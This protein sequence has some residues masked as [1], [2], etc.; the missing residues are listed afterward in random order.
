MQGVQIADIPKDTGVKVAEPITK[1]ALVSPYNGGNLGDA[2]IQEAMIANLRQR[3]PGAQFLGITLDCDNFVRQHGGDAFPL[4]PSGARLPRAQ[5]QPTLAVELGSQNL[6]LEKPPQ[7]SI[8]RA[9]RGIPGLR[10]L[11][12]SV[13]T[14]LI[15]VRR[16]ASH[17]RDGYR[18]VRGQDLLV[19]SGGGQLD[20][21]YGGGWR[22]PFAIWKWVFLAHLAK[23][24]CALASVGAGK[25]HQHASRFFVSQALRMCTY[26]SFRE[27]KSRAIVAGI[28]PRAV[29]DA[30]V[31]DL[32]F[33]LPD[34]L[35][36]SPSGEIRKMAQGRPVIALSPMAYLKPGIW[37]NGNATLYE[38]YV[39]QLAEV[40][41][42]LSRRGYFFVVACSSRY[43]DESVIPELLERLDVELKSNLEGRLH[44]PLIKSW[45][46]LVGVLRQS[47][48]LIASRLHGTI[49][50]FVAGTP[51]IA[52]SSDPKVDW[53]MEDLQQTDYLLQFRDFTAEDV[54]QAVDRLQKNRDTCVEHIRSYRRQLFS[55]SVSAKQ[56]D[57]L[58]GL[59]FQHRRGDALRESS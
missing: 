46:E 17:W 29:N 24:P 55:T 50:G 25:L 41:A 3:L 2:A 4:L 10:S 48:I 21:E 22:L 12:R 45:P 1:I 35:L 23:V 31:P 8:R 27:P 47:D 9:L 56:Y 26:R 16:H 36:P 39:Q 54:L 58:A 33:S 18:A 14:C 5:N 53:V 40:L 43:D 52:I 11:V 38:R 37:P 30:V 42:C 20:E 32:A 51:V 34:S 49:L 19:I 6:P 13:R 57:L 7:N 28:L 15:L 44:F 59:V